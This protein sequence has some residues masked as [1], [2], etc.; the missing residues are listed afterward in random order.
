MKKYFI[1][2]LISLLANNVFSQQHNITEEEQDVLYPISDQHKYSSSKN[3]F[4]NLG[5]SVY[6]LFIDPEI[7]GRLVATHRDSSNGVKISTDDGVN[8][9]P[10]SINTSF[11]QYL[12]C[13]SISFNP[14]NLN[15][16]FFAAGFDLFKTTNRGESWDSTNMFPEWYYEISYVVYHPL[17][18][19]VV[20]VS[21]SKP[22][23]YQVLLYKSEDGGNNWS[24]SDSTNY[25]KMVFHAEDPNI[26]YGISQYSLIKKSTNGGETW[27]KI[28]NNLGFSYDKVRV[29]EIGKN[30]PDVLYCGQYYDY[31]HETWRLAMTTN[32]GESWK[33]IDSTLLEIDP[34][35]SVGGILLD[36]TIE[37]RFYVSYTGGLYLT[38]DSGK[39]FQKV[40][41]GGA[42]DIWSDNNYPPN[43]YFNSKDG[44]MKFIDTLT[45]GIK[46]GIGNIPKT[47]NLFQNYPNPFNPVT[48]IKYTI[49]FEKPSV[50][51]QHKVSLKI[52]DILGKELE[53]LVNE[54]QTPGS[55]EV[56]F[57][58]SNLSSGVYFYQLK[59]EIFQATKKLIF[60]R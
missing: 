38:E 32:G 57:D 56:E 8:W 60:L 5:E 28:N 41:S 13:E 17:D 20:F 4:I 22:I 39:H 47:F 34:N 9:I 33:R 46:T 7:E 10:A 15:N 18:S 45:V 50:K 37:G 3:Y 51:S 21:N 6:D 59:T 2:L 53:T 44:L 12:N 14:N 1:I 36:P 55:Y 43:I 48:K 11:F 29:L 23:F 19:N 58:A 49:P 25:T 31:D 54:R 40:Y 24:V 27:E 16:G 26:I 35:G 52:Y 42:G 30:N